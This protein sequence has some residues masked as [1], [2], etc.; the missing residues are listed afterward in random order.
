MLKSS[1]H[2]SG[3][4]S[5][6]WMYKWWHLSESIIKKHLGGAG[7][8]AQWWSMAC[9]ILEKVGFSAPMLR[10]SWL[11]NANSEWANATF[12]LPAVS[13]FLNTHLY[14][15]R[16]IH[17]HISKHRNKSLSKK[18]ASEYTSHY[19]TTSIFFFPINWNII[20]I[21]LTMNHSLN[22]IAS[23]IWEFSWTTIIYYPWTVCYL[24]SPY[25]DKTPKLKILTGR[26][27][28]WID[29]LL[30][31]AHVCITEPEVRPNILAKSP[32]LINAVHP[33]V[34][35]T[36]TK[37][38]C[39]SMLPTSCSLYLCLSSQFPPP[40]NCLTICPPTVQCMSLEKYLR[41]KL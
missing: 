10:N 9:A 20:T 25:C 12:C 34:T 33:V 39:K 6:G 30:L 21:A 40:F 31:P 36:G 18:E 22:N 2:V 29:W 35:E 37:Y 16:F 13:A 27:N 23:G 28:D 7:E 17:I 4:W 41:S 3:F 38:A 14:I 5:E 15:H 26:K 8:E 19:V 32:K 11:P 1:Y 24:A